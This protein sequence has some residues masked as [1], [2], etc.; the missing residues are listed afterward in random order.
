M[1]HFKVPTSLYWQTKLFTATRPLWKWLGKF[2]TRIL[3]DDISRVEINKPVYICGLARSGTTIVTELL[4]AHRTLTSH[5]YSDFPFTHIPYWK[6]WL[7][8]H[9]LSFQAKPQ[10]RAHGDRIVVTQDSPEA[11]EEVIWMHFFNHLHQDERS[12]ILD[13]NTTNIEFQSFYQ[14]HIRKLL[15]IRQAKRYL[16][17]G[18]YNVSRVRYL[19]KLFPDARFVFMVRNPVHHIASLRKQHQ[20]FSGKPDSKPSELK[21][22]AQQMAASGHFE[23]GLLRKAIN[24]DD[25]VHANILN[26]WRQ[27]H[28]VTGWALYWNSVYRHLLRLMDDPQLSKNCIIVRYEDLCN[29]SEK[30]IQNILEHCKLEPNELE[31]SIKTF[32]DSFSLPDYYQVKFSSDEIKNIQMYCQQTADNFSYKIVDTSN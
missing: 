24:L 3:S 10:Q 8:Q 27:G 23:F 20:L 11:I 4:N 19:L 14:S 21:R 13:Q 2:E 17:K 5:R 31:P 25:G 9:K 26:A 29:D 22:A 16:S 32:A 30:Q 15:L 18:N 6:N 7:R 1:S 28:E 12:Q